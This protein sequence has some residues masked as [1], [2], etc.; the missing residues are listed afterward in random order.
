MRLNFKTTFL[1]SLCILLMAPFVSA[2]QRQS[3]NT[4]TVIFAVGAESHGST[5]V[6]L[7][8]IAFV[9]SRQFLET[10]GGDDFRA[11]FYRPNREYRLLFGGGRSGSV[12]VTASEPLECMPSGARATIRSSIRLTGDTM[13]LATNSERLGEAQSIRRAPTN[14][15]RAAVLGLVYREFRRRGAP[16]ASLRAVRVEN[17]AALDLNHDGR[18]ELVGNFM[19]RQARPLLARQ[20][21]IIAEQQA[22]GNYRLSLVRHEVIRQADLMGEVSATDIGRNAFLTETLIDSL[23]ADGDETDEIFT[24]ALSFEGTHYAIYR[25]EANGWRRAFESYIYRCAY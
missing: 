7:D 2:Q 3:G 9:N 8:P 15:E 25:R 11:E 12:R 5:N 24:R 17:L 14:A 23:D 20:L 21:F 22:G 16:A 4:N 13:A 10:S 18:H 6:T 1:Y 19:I